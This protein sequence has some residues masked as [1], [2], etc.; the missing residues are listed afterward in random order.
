MEL[1]FVDTSAFVALYNRL[2]QFHNL[3]VEKLEVLRTRPH[4]LVISNYIVD[5]TL[6]KLLASAGFAAAFR[7]G[8]RVFEKKS[9]LQIQNIDF[10]TEIE[11]WDVFKKFNK[12]KKWSFTDCTSFVLM[13]G[14]GIKT[15]FTFD[16]N[17]RQMGFKML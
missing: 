5:E 1:I 2:D 8:V 15:I 4:T 11:A 9:G 13:K 10:G 16:E 6:T 14:L 12:D 3:A 17:F 7:F